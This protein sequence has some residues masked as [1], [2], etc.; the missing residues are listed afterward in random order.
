MN[1]TGWLIIAI[2]VLGGLYS[3]F[4]AIAIPHIFR[5]LLDR[6][7][8]LRQLAASRGEVI[9]PE[10]DSMAKEIAKKHAEIFAMTLLTP[11]SVSI[12][13]ESDPA[14]ID[15]RDFEVLRESLL[16]S[17]QLIMWGQAIRFPWAIR[18]WLD[19]INLAYFVRRGWCKGPIRMVP[20][21]LTDV[22]KGPESCL[23]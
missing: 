15:G 23:Q 21:A 4:A 22:P 12:K 14:A 2:T 10:L 11:V 3:V 16:R 6:P 18:R 1:W 7:E 13:L 19:A 5:L 9:E 17:Y 8:R 20:T